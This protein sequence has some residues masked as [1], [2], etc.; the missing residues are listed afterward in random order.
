MK[1]ICGIYFD[2]IHHCHNKNNPLGD[3]IRPVIAEAVVLANANDD[4]TLLETARSLM[5]LASCSTCVPTPQF[6]VTTTQQEAITIEQRIGYPTV[7]KP[8][9]M[10]TSTLVAIAMTDIEL[11]RATDASTCHIHNTLRQK[12]NSFT[13]I[14]NFLNAQEVSAETVT[15]N[16]ATQIISVEDTSSHDRSELQHIYDA[17]PHRPGPKPMLCLRAAAFSVALWMIAGCTVGPNFKS[18]APRACYEL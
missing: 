2:A 10:P 11:I 9:D 15:V 8:T 6:S 18:P 5:R 14:G 7:V 17:N 13:L 1:Q 16:E 3:G 12:I 4:T